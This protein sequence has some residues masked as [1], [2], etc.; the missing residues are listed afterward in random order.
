MNHQDVTCSD[1]L[2]EITVVRRS[3]GLAAKVLMFRFGYVVI[4]RFIWLNGHFSKLLISEICRAPTEKPFANCM[5]FI[6]SIFRH[7]G[8]SCDYPGHRLCVAVAT[9]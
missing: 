6:N 2:Y 1:E 8:Y 3:F 5:F 4:V 7:G 9:L